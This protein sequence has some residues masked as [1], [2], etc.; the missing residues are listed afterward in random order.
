M[1]IR[2]CAVL[3]NRPPESTRE[4]FV[5]QPLEVELYEKK[6]GSSRGWP[7]EKD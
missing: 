7:V 4:N 2:R 5:G 3:E 6:I 1:N